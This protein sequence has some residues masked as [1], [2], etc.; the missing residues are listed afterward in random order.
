MPV[1][2]QMDFKFGVEELVEAFADGAACTAKLC[3]E[4][5][6]A[7]ELASVEL[8]ELVPFSTLCPSVSP[9]VKRNM[10]NIERITYLIF[11]YKPPC[12]PTLP[13]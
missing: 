10:I 9:E 1:I 5:A 7:V 2:D 6:V 12:F 11:K 13:R 4:L 3:V 8:A